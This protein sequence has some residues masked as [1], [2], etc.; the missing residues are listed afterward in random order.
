MA[1]RAAL[2]LVGLLFGAL[3]ACGD[4]ADPEPPA[5]EPQ[6]LPTV[7]DVRAELDGL[8]FD[9]LLDVSFERVLQ[10]SP[11]TVVELGL[12]AEIDVGAEFLDDPSAAFAAETG[13]VEAVV[14]ERLLAIDPAG[15]AR[16]QEIARQA[17]R[18]WLEDRAR[19]RELSDLEYRVTPVLNTV[20]VNTQLFFT[21]IHPVRSAD[22]ADRFVRRLGAVGG[23]MRRLRDELVRLEEGGVVAP[24][25]LLEWSRDGLRAVAEASPRENPFYAALAAGLD[26]L[27]LD[28]A[29]RDELLDRAARA[30]EES[31]IPGYRLL[32]ERVAAQVGRAPAGLGVGQYPG[33]DEYYAAAL[34]HHVTSPVDPDDLHELGLAELERIHAELDADFE[35]LGYPAAPLAQQIGRV[36]AESG[37]V[38]AEDVAAEYAAIIDDAEARVGEA[39]DLLPSADVIVTPVA[40]GGFYVGPSLDGSR[41]GAFFATVFGAGEDRFGMRTLAYHE[42]VPGHHLQIGLAQDLDLP[43]FQRVVGFTGFAEGWALYAEWLAGELGWYEG[44]LPGDVGRLQGEAFRA[45]R[46]VVDTGIHHRAWTFDQAVDFFRDA[47]GYGQGFAEGQV[48][49][50]ASWPGQATSYWMGRTAILDLL[51]GARAE[52]GE[53]FDLVAFH[54]AVLGHGSVPLDVLA[55]AVR[56]DLGLPDPAQG[57]ARP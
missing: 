49:R 1:G 47:T 37:L 27:E 46:L 28:A 42:A 39:F 31:V 56:A 9:A 38:P 20:A 25:L 14:L 32:D 55:F 44:D 33:G 17:Y 43:L 35:A 45:A 53:G 54:R 23:Q 26:D 4:N 34:A 50:Y 36:A 12:E 5:T 16:E 57:V 24:R 6:P 18:W 51:A 21:D 29:A 22:D 40:R 15:L 13:E 41:P 7:D 19:G 3:A 30:I 48:A 52:L 11:M 8:D 2:G 10:R